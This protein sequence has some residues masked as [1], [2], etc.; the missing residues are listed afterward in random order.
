[1]HPS[2]SCHLLE[3]LEAEVAEANMPPRRPFLFTQTGCATLAL[4]TYNQFSTRGIIASIR[5]SA[6]LMH[7]VLYLMKIS[8]PISSS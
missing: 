8:Y 6:S 7:I 2:S 3:S 5:L 4:S 1:V